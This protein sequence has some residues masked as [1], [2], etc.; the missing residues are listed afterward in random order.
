M[1][2]V[3]LWREDTGLEDT[4]LDTRALTRW[5]EATQF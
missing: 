5:G 1:V 3:R 4:G 2:V